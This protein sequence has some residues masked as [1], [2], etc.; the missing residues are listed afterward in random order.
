MS[1]K[2]ILY[3]STECENCVGVKAMLESKG[4]KFAFVDV[5]GGVGHLKRFLAVRDGNPDIFTAGRVGIPAVVVDNTEVY[6]NVTDDLI[7]FLL[8]DAE[9]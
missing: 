5:L 3:G 4:V 6:L 7:Q 2:V 1:K 9:Q 8:A